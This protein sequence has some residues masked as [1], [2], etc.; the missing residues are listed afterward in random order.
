LPCPFGVESPSKN[1]SAL[2]PEAFFSKKHKGVLL[3][4]N[5]TF[6]SFSEKDLLFFVKQIKKITKK[7]K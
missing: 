6:S 2:C 4:R 7:I 1:P 3:Y 5:I